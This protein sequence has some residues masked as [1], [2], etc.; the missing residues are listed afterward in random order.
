MI[1][2]V[3]QSAYFCLSSDYSYSDFFYEVQVNLM[4]AAI[5]RNVEDNLSIILLICDRFKTKYES[6]DKEYFKYCFKKAK[7]T[8][9]VGL[10]DIGVKVHLSEIRKMTEENLKD[11]NV[12]K[13]KGFFS[14]C[15]PFFD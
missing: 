15:L 12:K 8:K 3:Y 2:I 10:Q 6:A 11:K 5:N 14:C 13:K 7:C 1:R 9:R 4:N